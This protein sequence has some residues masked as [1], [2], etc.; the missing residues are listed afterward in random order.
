MK[1]MESA[2]AGLRED[3]GLLYF[4]IGFTFQTGNP[5]STFYTVDGLTECKF[6]SL[7]NRCFF[8]FFFNTAIIAKL[9][10]V[11]IIV[12]NNGKNIIKKEN[13]YL[14]TCLTNTLSC[15]RITVCAAYCPFL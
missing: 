15:V 9:F 3:L 7:T 13:V 6:Y 12:I 11:D 10:L 14:L 1:P 2:P 8:L 5:P 4:Y